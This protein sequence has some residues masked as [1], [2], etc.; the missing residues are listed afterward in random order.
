MGVLLD[1]GRDS[2]AVVAH[3]SGGLVRW[4][5][6]QGG[7]KTVWGRRCRCGLLVGGVGALPGRPVRGGCPFSESLQA[8]FQRALNGWGPSLLPR[9]MPTW[10]SRAY[11]CGCGWGWR[12]GAVVVVQ[13]GG[14]GAA[15]AAGRPVHATTDAARGPLSCSPD[16]PHAWR[17]RGLTTRPTR[18]VMQ[19]CCCLTDQ[20]P[21]RLRWWRQAAGPSEDQVKL[22][23][24]A[25]AV[26][27]DDLQIPA[28]TALLHRKQCEAHCRPPTSTSSSRRK[29]TNSAV[30]GG[31]ATWRHATC[32]APG[33]KLQLPATPWQ[34]EQF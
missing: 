18:W 16:T 1:G 19:H 32:R 31:Q 22:P 20:K 6:R 12:V 34:S 21:R 13:G 8:P 27:N 25:V 7:H 24:L 5:S 9:Q 23:Q 15:A 17:G 28:R 4:C 3:N 33:T 26:S 30:V 2:G 14:G 10:L 29:A 11:R